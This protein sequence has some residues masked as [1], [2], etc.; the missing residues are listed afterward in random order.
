M[1]NW[2]K[3]SNF[4]TCNSFT[5]QI[6]RSETFSTNIA[7]SRILSLFA[8]ISLLFF[9]S[10]KKDDVSFTYSPT[11]PRAGETIVFTNNTSEG[12]EWSWTFGDGT[13]ST[14]KSPRKVYKQP[15]EYS[16]ILKVDNK[17]SRT[18]SA[19][20]RIYDTVPAITAS[21]TT[22]LY[23]EPVTLTAS[24]YNPF[25]YSLSYTWLLPSEATITSGD[26]TSASLTLFFRRHS[27]KLPV[28]CI[29][30]Q[31]DIDWTI[32]TTFYV[33][34]NPAPTLIFAADNIFYRQR[35]Y[36]T[37]Y[38]Q[39]TTDDLLTSAIAH[40]TI[41]LSRNTDIS[42]ALQDSLLFVFLGDTTL[43]GQICLY[44][45]SA[46]TTS[47]VAYN[48][49]TGK[50]QTFQNG[51]LR[52]GLLFWTAED[53]VYTTLSDTR[54]APFSANGA[55]HLFSADE[56][57]YSLTTGR[58]SGGF[59]IYNS[60]CFYAYDNG[61]Y[62]FNYSDIGSGTTSAIGAVLQDYN[63]QHFAIDRI[64]QKIYFIGTT[65]SKSNALYVCNING[66]NIVMLDQ[67]ADGQALCVDANGNRVYWTTAD[68]LF[69]RGLI[70]T[71]NNIQAGTPEQ[72]NTISGIEAVVVL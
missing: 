13:T 14:Y 49:L 56:I 7:K 51:I 10:C 59:D 40:Q 66:S 39:P 29:I 46:N 60:I 68:G 17:N 70:H 71:Q 36:G 58:Q 43:S 50:G 2:S 18:Y 32:D 8:I 45:M 42:L 3:S 19:T 69:C 57:G 26:T 28:R 25:S 4:A 33:H 6:K 9:V 27:T 35:I 65:S 34:D 5:M 37:G 63:I 44:D 21:D 24:L 64:A 55:L 30:K 16:V 48:A 23:Y 1:Y 41:D 11:E 72:V 31:G 54:N 67:N 61:L 47:I 52:D 20:I 22:I 53:K 15:G 62:R 12:E 38:E